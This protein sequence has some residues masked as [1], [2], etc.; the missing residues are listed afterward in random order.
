MQD[1][2]L[3]Q[4]E[5]E[6][7]FDALD[8]RPV[9]RWLENGVGEQSPSIEGGEVREISDT[10]LDTEDW[11]I[12][13]AG[14]ALRVRRKKGAD[15]AEATMKLLDSENGTPGLKSRRE[16][17]ETLDDA[18]PE[19]LKSS[20]GPVGMR[21]QALSGP[22]ALR[23]LFEVETCRSTYGL[24]LDGSA[25]G[26][27][28]LDETTIPLENGAE[29]VRLRRVEVE[30]GPEEVPR[31]EPFVENLRDAC[32]LLP[33]VA[34]KYESGLFARG[35][36][37]PEPPEFGPTGV[38]GTLPTGEFAFRVMR[39]QFG[40]FL[41]HEP[42][43]R[44]GE[45]AEE[46]H[47]M[48]VA[49]R[50]MRAAMK[51]FEK[52]VPVRTQ[53]FRD[54]FKWVAGAL[55]EVRDLDV[56]LERLDLWVADAVE[57]DREPLRAL[58]ALLQEQREKQRKAMLRA[59]DSKRCGRLVESFGEFLRRGPSRRVQASRQPIL[60]SGPDLVRKPYRKFRKLGD[61]LTEESSGE[62]YHEL[63]K[64]GKRL[65]YALEF[66]SDIYGG[67]AEDLV[68]AL[69]RLQDILGDHQDAEVATSYLRELAV[70]RGRSPKLPPETVF[71]MGGIAHRYEVQARELRAEFPE[72]Y[73][74]VKGKRW[75]KL[76]GV[77]EKARPRDTFRGA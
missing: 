15:K 70:A 13:R 17:S 49:T 61:P 26:E 47:D 25:V 51:I 77:M 23:T 55:G 27:I 10:Y 1:R 30:V 69:K 63:R 19:A 50:R 53:K 58:R 31:L 62:A 40:I 7:Q 21:V 16:I 42:G 2:T 37:P 3:D 41:S 66:V 43:T 39:E 73:G 14:Y 67:P 35:L 48:R 59:L 11:R 36:A 64:K 57:R 52:A 18:D 72:A 29:S 33:A 5:V 71:V 12:K 76:R 4:Q 74:E 65:R 32:R 6:W 60:D 68:K 54:E 46:L 44:I 22:K 34:S 45:D 38:D 28:A 8:L 75:K 20:T 24:T 56:Q 9:G